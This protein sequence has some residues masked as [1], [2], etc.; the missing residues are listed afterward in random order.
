MPATTA[1]QAP[2]LDDDVAW[3]ATGGWFEHIEAARRADVLVVAPATASPT[4]VPPAT[5]KRRTSPSNRPLPETF[6]NS[7]MCDM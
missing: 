6:C 2:V 7:G 3:S 4:A 5:S 1:A